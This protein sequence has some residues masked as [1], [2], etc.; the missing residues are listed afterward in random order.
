[1]PEDSQLT[2]H[3]LWY[4]R[5]QTDPSAQRLQNRSYQAEVSFFP[6]TKLKQL[7]P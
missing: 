7:D 3:S 6:L 4:Q 5:P 1:M 2:S